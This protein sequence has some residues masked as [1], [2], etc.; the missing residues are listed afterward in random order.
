M[1]QT[2]RQV[3]LLLCALFVAASVKAE[4]NVPQ[5][6]CRC[7]ASYENLYNRRLDQEND[8]DN[9]NRQLGV[10]FSDGFY[11]INGIRVLPPYSSECSN[12]LPAGGGHR[13]LQQSFSDVNEELKAELEAELEQM[14]ENQDI[15]TPGTR[16]SLSF[17]GS[18]HEGSNGISFH[19]GKV[20][21]VQSD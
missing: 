2:M 14:E 12:S 13:N 18:F 21:R 1:I 6:L 15:L 16:R 5:L 3:A 9:D 11:T 10:V 19:Q 20:S 4:H 17:G 7:E 8:N